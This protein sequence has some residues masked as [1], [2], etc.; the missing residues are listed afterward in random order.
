[1]RQTTRNGAGRQQLDTENPPRQLA[2]QRIPLR[3]NCPFHLHVV[4]LPL[5]KINEHKKN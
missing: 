5:V 4:V 1:M 3:I 2:K